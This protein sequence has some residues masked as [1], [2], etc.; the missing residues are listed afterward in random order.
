MGSDAPGHLSAGQLSAPEDQ[1][2]LHVPSLTSPPRP[3]L[4]HSWPASIPPH[5]PSWCI[6]AAAVPGKATCPS[7]T[8]QTVKVAQACAAPFI[9]ACKPSPILVTS[10][11]TCR[12]LNLSCRLNRS[13]KF[14]AL[15][16][17]GAHVVACLAP[18]A[19]SMDRAAVHAG[20]GA[21]PWLREGIHSRTAIAPQELVL[22]T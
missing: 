6:N 17:V 16:A 7:L 11:R 9:S 5:M 10:Q 1:S 13:R 8:A 12:V 3:S 22:A 4:L 18:P 14:E 20:P 21:P 15:A 2:G 19:A